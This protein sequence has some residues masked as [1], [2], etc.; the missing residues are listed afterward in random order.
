[1]K[2]GGHQTFPIREGWLAKALELIENEPSVFM[3]NYDKPAAL[4]VGS[5]MAKSIEHWLV[6][7]GLAYKY[8]TKESRE[9]NQKYELTNL[10]KVIVSFD[11]YFTM[12]ETW[13]II[14]LNLVRDPQNAATWDWFFNEFNETRFAKSEVISRIKQREEQF[15]GKTP[16]DTTLERDVACFL[17]TYAEPVPREN[18]DPEEDLGCPLHELKLMSHLRSS[19][20]YEIHRQARKIPPELLLYSI[21]RTLEDDDHGT[22]F[23]FSW[24]SK[25][26]SGP[27]QIFMLTTEGL[28]EQV[29][30]LEREGSFCDFKIRD[31]AGD[32]QIVLTKPEK[33]KLLENMYERIL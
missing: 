26:R 5:N 19:A 10:G 4:G 32:R 2:Y 17:N 6:A 8:G 21:I 13:W 30:G 14:H 33:S 11:P 25:Q 28:F 29:M 15:S 31:L 16:S 27:L 12:K 18:K 7:T 20:T 23:T 24:L 3:N 22:D 1:M 9:L